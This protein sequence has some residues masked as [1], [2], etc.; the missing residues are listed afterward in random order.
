MPVG[1]DRVVS[2]D[3]DR[4]LASTRATVGPH[5]RKASETILLQEPTEAHPSLSR[6]VYNS[7]EPEQSMHEGQEGGNERYRGRQR[8]HKKN[9]VKPYKKS[10]SYRGQKRAVVRAVKCACGWYIIVPNH[11]L[12]G[13]RGVCVGNGRY[14]HRIKKP[15]IWP[16][17]NLARSE[18]LLRSPSV[19]F[20]NL[21]CD[22]LMINH[23][24]H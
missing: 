9:D 13:S 14:K 15:R 24:I 2:A 23:I 1:V 21:N 8:A 5:S 17:A 6:Q 10:K 11:K 7:S 3:H 22:G 19:Y 12:V 4:L 18:Q 16:Q 20:F